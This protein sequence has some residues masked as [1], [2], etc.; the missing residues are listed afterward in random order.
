MLQLAKKQEEYDHAQIAIEA[1]Q[2]KIAA[3]EGENEVSARRIQ[4]MSAQQS[5]RQIRTRN[6]SEDDMYDELLLDDDNA[7]DGNEESLLVEAPSFASPSR[8]KRKL[9]PTLR[10]LRPKD[11]RSRDARSKGSN[12]IAFAS[13]SEGREESPNKRIKSVQGHA[14][15]PFATVSKENIHLKAERL[16]TASEDRPGLTS[17][18]RLLGLPQDVIVLDASSDPPESMENE[19]Q[20]LQMAR[21]VGGRSKDGSGQRLLVGGMRHVLHSPVGSKARL[22]RRLEEQGNRATGPRMTRRAV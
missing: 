13:D 19:V 16:D 11:I 12:V 20:L 14:R 5:S 7:M 22:R 21:P 9:H 17:K 18:S 2:R 1:C 4:E 15:N 8:R 10:V 6:L 3:L